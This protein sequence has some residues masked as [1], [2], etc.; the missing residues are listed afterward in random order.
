MTPRFASL[1][2]IVGLAAASLATGATPAAA[3]GTHVVVG[4]GVGFAPGHHGGYG[5]YG[6]RPYW[7]PGYYGPRYYYPP[8]VVF[9][10]PPYYDPPPAYYPPPPVY[11]APPP[12]V[13][14]PPQVVMMGAPPA[15]PGWQPGQT[16]CREWRGPAQIDGRIQEMYGTVCRQPDGSWRF[17]N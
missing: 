12:A 9:V 13:Y 8:P 3:G 10:P 7:G 4:V 14:A 2:Q 6:Y 15:S 1:A 5:G 17:Q 11:Y 16:Y